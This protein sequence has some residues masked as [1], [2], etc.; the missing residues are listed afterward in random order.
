LKHGQRERELWPNEVT[1]F[2][3]RTDKDEAYFDPQA[4]NRLGTLLSL[5]MTPYY[6]TKMLMSLLTVKDCMETLESYFGGKTNF[7]PNRVWI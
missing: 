2:S 1:L 7:D 4:F 3:L 6:L 5:P